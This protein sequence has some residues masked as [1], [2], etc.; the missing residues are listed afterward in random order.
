MANLK[1]KKTKVLPLNPKRPKFSS[2]EKRLLE[3][4][5]AID[6]GLYKVVSEDIAKSYLEKTSNDDG[7]LLNL[8]EH[9]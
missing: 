9:D 3:L 4:Q 6:Q 7:S 5:A 2:K 8:I 1:K